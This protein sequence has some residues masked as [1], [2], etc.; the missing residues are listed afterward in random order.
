MRRVRWLRDQRFANDP[1]PLDPDRTIGQGRFTSTELRADDGSNIWVCAVGT[2]AQ[3][4]SFAAF[5]ALVQQAY[6]NFSGIGSLASSHFATQRR[7]SILIVLGAL[8]A[9]VLAA[10]AALPALIDRF[11]GS[12]DPVRIAVAVL[13]VGPVG[14]CL[15]CFMP[16]GLRSVA[17]LSARVREYVAW[18][19]AINGFFSVIA[20]ILATILAMVIGFRWLLL[21]ALAIYF[22]GAW[23]LLRL[24]EVAERRAP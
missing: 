1:D 3:F 13:I 11:V 4:G 15:G 22:V 6:L 12:A 18:A 5:V 23:A 14:L 24:P 16:L 10:H 7:R 9:W 20:S 2:R 8:T 21:V 17:S 19:W